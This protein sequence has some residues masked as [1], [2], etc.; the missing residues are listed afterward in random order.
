MKFTFTSDTH[1]G[2]SE[3]THKLHEYLVAEMRAENPDLYVLAG[4]LGLHKK[5]HFRKSLEFFRAE[6]GDKPIL[7]VR[8]NHDFQHC[9]FNF[10]SME[11][12]IY[13]KSFSAM[14]M[15]QSEW[16]AKFNIHHLESGPFDI[17]GFRFVGWDGWYG[18]KEEDLLRK[19]D[20]IF[21]KTLKKVRM[22]SD[23]ER[24]TPYIDGMKTFAWLGERSEQMFQKAIQS[25]KEHPGGREK[26]VAITHM[27]PYLT[28]EHEELHDGDIT[29][30]PRLAPFAAT[31][32]HG[33]SHKASDQIIEGVRVL[34]A[35]SD[36]DKPKFKTIVVGL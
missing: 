11:W 2:F 34:N 15:Q 28:A 36:Y 19:R 22:P 23:P 27:P 6:L 29:Q 14:L 33:H 26:V 10:H 13:Q 8:G 4:D 17:G 24:L 32:L 20:E 5:E 21:S 35:G 18:T 9:T 1:R 12:R 25:A 7:L 3:K 16:F 31:L 30:L